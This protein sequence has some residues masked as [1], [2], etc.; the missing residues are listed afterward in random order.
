MKYKFDV[1]FDN[2]QVVYDY[3]ETDPTVPAWAKTPEKP[4]Y[5]AE[6]VGADG[7]G[8]AAAALA[9]AKAYTDGKIADIPVPDVSNQISNHNTSD[10]AHSDIRALVTELENGIGEAGYITEGE[11]QSKIS[12]H[13]TNANAHSDIRTLIAELEESIKE[14]GDVTESEV[15]SKISVHNTNTSAHGDIRL[16]I[17]NL[18]DRLNALANSDDTTLDQMAEI[19]AYIKDNRELIESVT[20]SKV[21][22]TDIIDN[23]T[24]NVANKPLSAAQGVVLKGLIDELASSSGGGGGEDLLNEDGVL[25][26][27]HLPEGYPYIE[28][29]ITDYLDGIE[30]TYVEGEGFAIPSPAPAPT[31]GETYT[32]VW[33]GVEY[34]C[35]ATACEMGGTGNMSAL[36]DIGA[37]DGTPTGEY[38]FFIGYLPSEFVELAGFAGMAEPLDGSTTLTLQILG[39]KK[40]VTLLDKQYLPDGYPSVKSNVVLVEEQTVTLTDGI[41]PVS[42]A[43]EPQAGWVGAMDLYI[44]GV[45]LSGIPSSP[46]VEEEVNGIKVYSMVFDLDSAQITLLYSLLYMAQFGT[47]GAIR[48]EGGTV[49]EGTISVVIPEAITPMD[50]KFI[51]LDISD[52]GGSESLITAPD[53]LAENDIPLYNGT[54][55]TTVNKDS[56][57]GLPTVTAEDN[58]KFL[59]VENG[60]W[61]AVKLSDVS[62]EG[63]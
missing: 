20:T 36:G 30:L 12:V 63:A 23:L 45:S 8:S 39:N 17:T 21:S 29:G 38:P 37:F 50:N 49:T 2:L 43:T 51:S 24:T 19:V 31:I 47:M 26:K 59:M 44:S 10:T 61:A 5:T 48:V 55:W 42:F 60:V 14:A 3:N 11:V 35:V 56:L 15:E 28:E 16:L 46:V 18:T 62:Q 53:T 13:N 41:G 34:S 33:N 6:E 9:T 22:I 57:G 1:N 7:E 58:G 52:I 54:E 25:K 32:V 27:E 40:I 4:Q